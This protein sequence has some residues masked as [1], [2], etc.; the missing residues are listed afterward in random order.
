MC[1]GAE[2]SFLEGAKILRNGKYDFGWSFLFTRMNSGYEAAGTGGGLDFR[3]GIGLL[4]IFDLNADLSS[5]SNIKNAG[6]DVRVG[7]PAELTFHG[8]RSVLSLGIHYSVY[9]DTVRAGVDSSGTDIHKRLSL[10]FLNV[11]VELTFS[12]EFII[13]GSELEF[14]TGMQIL[15]ARCNGIN[16]PDGYDYGIRSFLPSKDELD[17]YYLSKAGLVF[18]PPAF[19]ITRFVLETRLPLSNYSRNAF[20]TTVAFGLLISIEPLSRASTVSF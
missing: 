14:F 6:I 7:P 12:K 11:P 9:K 16:L 19:K 2:A 5:N 17:K 8:F 1:L 4:S 20:G 10:Y 3:A 18:R 13:D 15:F